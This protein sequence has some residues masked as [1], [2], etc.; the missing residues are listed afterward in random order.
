MLVFAGENPGNGGSSYLSDV[1]ALTWDRSTASLP[2]P[3]QESLTLA[4]APNPSHGPT[5][6]DF[7]LLREGAARLDVF[8]LLGRSVDSVVDGKLGAGHHRALWSSLG[9]TPGIY[10]VRLNTASQSSIRRMVILP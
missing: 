5:T 6:I 8:D 9:R 3:G 1:W 4:V 7:Q 10:F 2:E